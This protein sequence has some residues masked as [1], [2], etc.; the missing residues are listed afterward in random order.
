MQKGVLLVVSLLF[1]SLFFS[2]VS[3]IEVKWND[4]KTVSDANYLIEAPKE[5][6][7]CNISP[8]GG[9]GWDDCS[10]YLVLKPNRIAA[11]MDSNSF[12]IDWFKG[13]PKDLTYT[14]FS[15]TALRNQTTCSPSKGKNQKCFNTTYRIFE[16]EAPLTTKAILFPANQEMG[17]KINFKKPRWKTDSFNFTITATNTKLD[18]DVSACGKLVAAGAYTLKNNIS[19]NTDC[20]S[21][22]ANNI[23]LDCAGYW[24]N[25][26]KTNDGRGIYTNASNITIKNCWIQQVQDQNFPYGIYLDGYGTT[27]YNSTIFI[28]NAY[29]GAGINV[30]YSN[31]YVD[32]VNITS[33]GFQISGIRIQ[34]GMSGDAS[35]NTF[36]NMVI[37][38]TQD[39]GYCEHY[40]AA[41]HVLFDLQENKAQNNYFINTAFVGQNSCQ[42]FNVQHDDATSQGNNFFLNSSNLNLE[43]IAFHSDTDETASDLANVTIQWFVQANVTYANGTIVEGADVNYTDHQ[44]FVQNMS[45]TDSQGLTNWFVANETTLCGDG[46]NIEYTPHNFTAS[47]GSSSNSS[48]VLVTSTKIIQLSIP[49]ICPICP[50]TLTIM[51]KNDGALSNFMLEAVLGLL[52]IAGI[53]AFFYYAT[54]EENTFYR[55]FFMFF[56]IF[57]LITLL[58]VSFE[59]M[60]GATTISLYDSSDVYTGKQVISAAPTGVLN[61]MLNYADI[62]MYVPYVL[63][64]VGFII[65]I[66]NTFSG[67]WTNKKGA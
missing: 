34:S 10:F 65:F 58:F 2:S 18:P 52:G 6:N 44:S 30:V 46:N 24:I 31:N 55:I 61:Q 62:F 49:S 36:K 66:L 32:S 8:D 7:L 53:F 4:V 26:S 33:Y 23:I 12:K 1:F 56:S 67:V 47:Y 64:S 13:L 27:I 48:S 17:L 20:I 59:S 45:F 54:P 50:P 37:N 39:S 3:A 15:T 28:Q 60:K 43:A 22:W 5:S 29:E 21:I 42:I 11:A 16:S 35:N 51:Y 9:S 41:Y 63:L 57:T 38:A 14:V 25:Y 40:S 19:G